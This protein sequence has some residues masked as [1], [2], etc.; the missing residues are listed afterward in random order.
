MCTLLQLCARKT[1]TPTCP[2]ASR[3]SG[4]GRVREDTHDSSGVPLLLC[5][6]NRAAVVSIPP[7]WTVT[8]PLPPHPLTK[9]WEASRTTTTKV[10]LLLAH[11]VAVP[12]LQ[13]AMILSLMKEGLLL[14]TTCHSVQTIAPPA[15]S[16]HRGATSGPLQSPALYLLISQRLR[17]GGGRPPPGPPRTLRVQTSLTQRLLAPR[18]VAQGGPN[19]HSPRGAVHSPL[20]VLCPVHSSTLGLVVIILFVNKLC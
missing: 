7:L 13:P 5:L 14:T 1:P 15:P 3:V 4:T 19:S 12:S 11:S 9:I 10:L 8:C 6:T 16:S 18:S 2:S 20:K 17:A